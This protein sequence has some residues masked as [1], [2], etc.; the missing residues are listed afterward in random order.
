MHRC[1]TYSEKSF[2]LS[3]IRIDD[4]FE[5][6][7]V[8]ERAGLPTLLFEIK[9]TERVNESH[10]TTLVKVKQD[11]KNSKAILVSNDSIEKSING[12]DCIHWKKAFVEFG[13]VDC[14]L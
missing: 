4:N 11:I 8:V 14:M 10:T 12:V 5:V 6:D 13:L 7:L 1:L 2:R 3:F 9:S